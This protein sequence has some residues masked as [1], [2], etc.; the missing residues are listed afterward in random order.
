MAEG[1]CVEGQAEIL[2]AG[3]HQGPR[4]MELLLHMPLIPLWV[5]RAGESMH[6]DPGMCHMLGRCHRW[7]AHW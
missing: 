2:H 7:E 5:S 4:A 6:C 3:R 1:V